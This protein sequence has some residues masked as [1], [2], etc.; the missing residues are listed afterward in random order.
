MMRT[1]KSIPYTEDNKHDGDALHD[2]T[3]F[4]IMYDDHA[5]FDSRIPVCYT[6]PL[7][8]SS[9]ILLLNQLTWKAQSQAK[10]ARVFV[11]SQLNDSTRRDTPLRP[12]RFLR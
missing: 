1:V 4:L 10:G 11:K 8:L 3:H 9:N 6:T 7:L 12:R 5:R 2:G